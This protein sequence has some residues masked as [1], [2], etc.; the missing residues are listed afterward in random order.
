MQRP[1]LALLRSATAEIHKEVE[2]LVEN[3]GFFET[4]PRYGEYLRRLH[5]FYRQFEKSLTSAGSQWL[6]PWHVAERISWLTQDLEALAIEPIPLDH[7]HPQTRAPRSLDERGSLLGAL[8]VLLG[9]S[10]GARVLIE[11]TRLLPLPASGGHIYLKNVGA[12]AL[13]GDYLQALETEPI[14]SPDALRQGAV[15]TFQS[16]REHLSKAYCE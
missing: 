5:L 13:W 7:A 6:G 16:I 15:D 2:K 14:G 9:A 1:R 12:T 8:Y 3:A 10:L 11:R 4:L